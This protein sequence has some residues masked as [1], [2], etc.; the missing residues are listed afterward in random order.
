M[1]NATTLQTNNNKLSANNT[2]LAS[3][4]NTIN[5]LPEAG[6][7]SGGLQEENVSVTLSITSTS[8]SYIPD[9]SYLT[10]ENGQFVPKFIDVST[11]NYSA[12]LSVAKGSFITLQKSYSTSQMNYSSVTG[13]IETFADVYSSPYNRTIMA[14]INGGGALSISSSSSSGG[15][16]ID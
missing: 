1:S 10:Y 5:N 16:S 14:Q 12:T 8:S 3:I 7:S 2:D 13:D 11:N 15:G 4:L 9:V 6:G